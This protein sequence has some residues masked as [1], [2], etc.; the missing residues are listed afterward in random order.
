MQTTVQPKL[1][2]NENGRNRET[3]AINLLSMK[4]LA[5]G[6]SE[7]SSKSP[8]ALLLAVMIAL[9]SLGCR[10]N[11]DQDMING[12]EE[13]E[14]AKDDLR[15]SVGQAETLEERSDAIDRY[16]KDVMNSLDEVKKDLPEKSRRATAS[17]QAFVRRDQ[18]AGNQ[19]QH[20]FAKVE[21]PRILDF[22]Q[23]GN[24]GEYEYQRSILT[25]YVNQARSY[26]EFFDSN[27]K[28]FQIELQALGDDNEF[29]VGMRNGLQKR[30]PKQK[31]IVHA[32]LDTHVKYGDTMLRLVKFLEQRDGTWEMEGEQVSLSTDEDVETFNALNQEM[33]KHSEQLVYWTN[34]QD[35]LLTQ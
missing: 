21:D 24:E 14:S 11:A 31:Q 10:Q 28:N 33:V 19:F 4:A 13:L 7:P 30:F 15:A 23:F 1:S 35:K 20:A 34:E 27:V 8:S 12:I 6:R 25:D 17:L 5:F 16:N 9:T 26:Q 2:F 18:E 22:S 3:S 29:V 32:L